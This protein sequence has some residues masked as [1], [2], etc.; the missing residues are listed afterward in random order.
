[1]ATE[2]VD[3]ADVARMLRAFVKAVPAETAPERRTAR[4]LEGAAVGLESLR[5][6]PD[7]PVS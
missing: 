4:R 2:R 7:S 5:N 1:M 3:V 6:D